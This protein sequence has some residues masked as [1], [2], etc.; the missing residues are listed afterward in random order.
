MIDPRIAE[1]NYYVN[2][3]AQKEKLARSLCDQLWVPPVRKAIAGLLSQFLTNLDGDPT[4]VP[5]K[6]RTFSQQHLQTLDELDIPLQ[7]KHAI[8]REL[9]DP[10]HYDADRGEA[11]ADRGEA[12]IVGL[13]LGDALL[14]RNRFNNDIV[15]VALLSRFNFLFVIGVT[16]ATRNALASKDHKLWGAFESLIAYENKYHEDPKHFCHKN[17]MEALKGWQQETDIHEIW[18]LRAWGMSYLVPEVIS[19]LMPARQA[20][21]KRF[22]QMAERLTFPTIASAMLY[23]LE[24]QYDFDQL[25]MLLECS[26]AVL[27]DKG[28]WNRNIMAPLLLKAAFQH[29]RELGKPLGNADAVAD[30]DEIRAKVRSI[31]SVLLAR[32][33]G[34]YL[35]VNWLIHLLK[36]FHH[37]WGTPY[38]EALIDECIVQLVNN[39]F[40]TA[41]L[42]PSIEKPLKIGILDLRQDTR[43]DDDGERAYFRFLI[44]LLLRN[45][46]PVIADFREAFENLLI[47]ARGQFGFSSKYQYCWQHMLVANIYLT[48]DEPVAAGW[49]AAFDR[50]APMLR[51]DRLG[52]PGRDLGGPSLFLAG[53]G[54]AMLR[55][56]TMPSAQPAIAVQ[57]AELWSAIFDA[58]FH[59]Y[60]CSDPFN[61]W[62]DVIEDLFRCYPSIQQYGETSGSKA[63]WTYIDRV[64]TDDHLLTLII[65]SLG[66]DGIDLSEV[67][68]DKHLRDNIEMR[69]ST[70]LAWNI[71]FESQPSLPYYVHSYWH[72]R[73][74]VESYEVPMADV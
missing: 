23:A 41:T 52:R 12:I 43:L 73:G 55:E 63:L 5:E 18:N 22:L 24:I 48:E 40:P 69:I 67:T 32:P 34:R 3:W 49:R 27:D 28:Y 15:P 13:A 37:T 68:D 72:E 45:K 35:S 57:M 70:Y 2:Q 59:A 31:Q 44:A 10:M 42:I 14:G 29:L 19:L 17:R 62:A 30:L 47:T 39:Q 61:S 66:R 46:M 20:D 64:G 9:Q 36:P 11:I 1:T 26:P 38:D 60:V 51:R 58:A 6:L 21:A 50:F 8:Y 71:Q 25:L 4:D 65:T 54:I 56:G 53:V 74:F 7:S 33:D 16:D